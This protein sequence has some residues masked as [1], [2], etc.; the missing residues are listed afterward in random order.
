MTIATI[1]TV[2]QKI[3][4]LQGEFQHPSRLQKRDA[5]EFAHRQAKLCKD[6]P[7]GVHRVVIK[8]KAGGPLTTWMVKD[9]AASVGVEVI[10]TEPQM[11]VFQAV[12][13]VVKD[14]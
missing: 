7:L 2:E 4:R 1:E 6:N 5:R 9:A 14:A 11:G 3:T 12:Y 10:F 13:S 8:F